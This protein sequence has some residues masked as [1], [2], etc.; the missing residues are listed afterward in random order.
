MAELEIIGRPV[1][2]GLN[3]QPAATELARDLQWLD[4]ALLMAAFGL[5]TLP[6]LLLIGAGSQWLGRGLNHA[7]F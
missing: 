4:G 7:E 6:N 3:F 2:G 5:G 1:D